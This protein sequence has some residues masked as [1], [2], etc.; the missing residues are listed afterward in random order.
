MHG[1]VRPPSGSTLTGVV[2]SGTWRARDGVF[3][4]IGG[5][6]NLGTLCAVR[7]VCAGV[8]VWCSAACSMQH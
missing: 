3:V 4:I 8:V 2:P 5:N 1:A 6:G 7:R